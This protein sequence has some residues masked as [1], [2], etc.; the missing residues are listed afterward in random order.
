MTDTIAVE[1]AIARVPD[2]FSRKVT[3]VEELQGLTN[4]SFRVRSGSS[5]Y[6]L[7]LDG[8]QVREDGLDRGRELAILQSAAAAG[9]APQAVYADEGM[10][11]TRWVDGGSWTAGELNGKR[12]E[13]IA[14]LL[15]RV[16]GLP[17]CGH[18][19]DPVETAGRYFEQIPRSGNDVGQARERLAAIEAASQPAGLCL[20]H[21]DVIAAN[22]VGGDRPI[23]ID[24]EYACDNH[25]LFDL[26]CLIEYH[27]LDARKADTLLS[28]YA[29]GATPETS[30]QLEEQRRLYAALQFLWFAARRDGASR[31]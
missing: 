24:W 10:L 7:R 18:S 9:L 31:P 14:A 3:V 30:E 2:W 15:R 8:S 12:L 20:C 17:L 4:R 29:G 5:D 27:G 19:L 22:I 21:N 1:E 23:L 28:A 16:H 13:S 26:A 6:A 11:V 25:P